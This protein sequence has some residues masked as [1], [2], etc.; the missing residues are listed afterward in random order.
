MA[1]GRVP[2][3]GRPIDTGGDDAA[4]IRAKRGGLDCARVLEERGAWQSG[5]CVKHAYRGTASG[6]DA[7]TVRAERG[8]LH[9]TRNLV[10]MRQWWAERLCGGCVPHPRRVVPTG[11]DDAATV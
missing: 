5:G 11:G 2:Q 8:R 10:P 7:A 3:P 9:L 1:G 4:T 6:D